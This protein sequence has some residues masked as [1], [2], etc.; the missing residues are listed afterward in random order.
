MGNFIEQSSKNALKRWNRTDDKK[1]FRVIRRTA[2]YF[3]KDLD[4][5]V[6]E[7]LDDDMN[8]YWE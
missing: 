4:A 7:I 6:T 3:N 5:F 8:P 1:L 2:E